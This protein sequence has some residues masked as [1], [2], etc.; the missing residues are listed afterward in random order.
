MV[1]VSIYSKYDTNT[2]HDLSFD[3]QPG[4]ISNLRMTY[5]DRQ[6]WYM[7]ELCGRKYDLRLILNK[8]IT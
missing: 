7:E 4:M 1:G 8:E 5:I 2:R 3:E 6:R